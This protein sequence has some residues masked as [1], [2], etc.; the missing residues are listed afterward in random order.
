[1]A[2]PWTGKIYIKAK[3]NLGG[4]RDKREVELGEKWRERGGGGEAA[5]GWMEARREGG[6]GS[7]GRRRLLKCRQEERS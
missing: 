1:M 3:R 4:D 2:K 5:G 6:E 7:V